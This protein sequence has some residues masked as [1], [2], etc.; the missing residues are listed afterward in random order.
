MEL[1]VWVGKIHQV[2]YD[3]DPDLDPA[4]QH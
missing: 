1:H 3:A 4:S 2:F